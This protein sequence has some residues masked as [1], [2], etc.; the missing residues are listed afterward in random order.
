MGAGERVA[1]GGELLDL[2]RGEG[3]ARHDR[4]AS[5][6]LSSTVA[7][8]RAEKIGDGGPTQAFGMSDG[9]AA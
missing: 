5:K 1:D 6:A 3:E 9:L 4:G 2:L 8:G 7:L